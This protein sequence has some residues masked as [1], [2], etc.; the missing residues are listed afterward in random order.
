MKFIVFITKLCPLITCHNNAN[1]KLRPKAPL[2]Q[3]FLSIKIDKT[4]GKIFG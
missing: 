3:Y 4:L 1:S 2:L